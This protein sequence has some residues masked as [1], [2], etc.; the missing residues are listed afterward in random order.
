MGHTFL[1]HVPT[2]A[3]ANRAAAERERRRDDELADREAARRARGARKRELT[4]KAMEAQRRRNAERDQLPMIVADHVPAQVRAVVGEL[5]GAGDRT[6]A[7]RR[8]RLER[9]ERTRAPLYS[10]ELARTGDDA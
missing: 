4:D 6:P 10:P 1:G 7:E 3:A 2:S 9:R 5:A 8:A